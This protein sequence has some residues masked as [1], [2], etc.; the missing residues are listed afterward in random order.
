MKDFKQFNIKDF[1]TNQLQRNTA[2]F[3]QQLTNNPLLDGVLLE[4]LSVSTSATD[5]AHG[6]GRAPRGYFVVKASA[7]AAVFDTTSVTPTTTLKLTSSAT[8]TISLWVF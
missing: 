6:L 5:F 4:G 3:T 8:A 1:S 2:E 7:A